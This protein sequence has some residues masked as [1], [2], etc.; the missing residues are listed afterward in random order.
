MWLIHRVRKP[1]GNLVLLPFAWEYV[2]LPLLVLRGIYHYW[3]SVYFSR[4]RI[5][6]EVSGLPPILRQCYAWREGERED[7]GP[8]H[9]ADSWPRP[10][11]IC[12]APLGPPVV[13]FLTPF[14]VGRVPL[15]KWTTEKGYPYSKLSTGGLSNKRASHLL[16]KR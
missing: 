4:G 10:A 3:I 2:I 16:C 14:L 9:A 6:M 13:P 8:G 12:R 1:R 7:G 5:R 11:N 15:L